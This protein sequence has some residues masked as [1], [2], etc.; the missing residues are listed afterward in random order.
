M[1]VLNRDTVAEGRRI[2][3]RRFC[4]AALAD[5]GD[6]AAVDGWRAGLILRDLHFASDLGGGAF[7][8]GDVGNNRIDA[9]IAR[10]VSVGTQ[11]H[12]LAVDDHHVL[13]LLAVP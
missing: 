12:G 9:S 3:V 5:A 11:L 1:P 7:V 8:V 2:A 13:A 10:A 4:S 6:G